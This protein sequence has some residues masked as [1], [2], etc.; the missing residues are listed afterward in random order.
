[1]SDTAKA[2]R[3][4]W[5]GINKANAKESIAKARELIKT[6]EGDQEAAGYFSGLMTVASAFGIDIG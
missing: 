6:A 4:L 1:M 5:L 2:I 3:K